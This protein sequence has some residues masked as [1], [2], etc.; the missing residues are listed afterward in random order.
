MRKKVV[1]IF[2][3]TV[4]VVGL[5]GCAKET[6]QSQPL[7]RTEI[8]MGTAVTIKIYDNQDEKIMDKVFKRVKEMEDLVSIN[9][10]GTELDRLNENAGIKPINVSDF[11]LEIIEKGLEYSRLSNG[12]YDITIGPLVKLWS[13]GLPEA[14]VPTEQEI[15]ETIKYVD[16]SKVKINK[17]KNEIFLAEKG[18]IIDLGSIAKGY[19]ADEIAKLLKDEGV[20]KAIIDFGGNIYALGSKEKDKKWKVGIQNP[21]DE[22]GNIVGSIKIEDKSLVTTGVYE[23]FIKEDETTYHHILNPKTGYPFETNIQ[24]VSIIADKSIDADALSTLIFTEGLE[25]GLK[26]I[27]SLDGIDAIFITDKKEVF[28]TDGIKNNFELTNS[29][30]KLAN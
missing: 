12:G 10:D 19:A 6:K 22:R 14:K 27:E 24:G 21:F 29:D 16:Y 18:M 17:S 26:L 25:N 4:L 7:S 20:K 13:I 11:T 9:K 15:K 3:L 1:Y 8:F 5:I 2:M 30:F 23:R 28:I